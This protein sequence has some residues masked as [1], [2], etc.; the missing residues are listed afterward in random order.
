MVADSVL[1]KEKFSKA[2]KSY[3]EISVIQREVADELYV[4]IKPLD[5]KSRILDVGIGTGYLSRKMISEYPDLRVSGID[6]AMGMLGICRQKIP[7]AQLV[8]S[9]AKYLPFKERSF[10]LV[11]SNLAYQWVKDIKQ[12]LLSARSVLKDRSRIYFSVFTDNT[13]QELREVIFELSRERPRSIGRLPSKSYLGQILREASFKHIKIEVEPKK[14]Y[15]NNLREL[16]S[17]LKNIGAN[18][19]WAEN[20]YGGLSARNFIE[21]IAKKYEERF[22][23]KGKIFAT[24]EVIY[25]EAAK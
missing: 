6:L 16:L 4:R 12:A 11:V 5:P 22:M 18:R 19:Y 15:Y 21:S 10:D 1:I 20:L 17:W 13:L 23:E 25:A 14:Q 8:Q 24:F 7:G 3:D 9:D 2:S